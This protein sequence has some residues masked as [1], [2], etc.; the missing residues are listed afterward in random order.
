MQ[1]MLLYEFDNFFLSSLNYQ[2]YAFLIEMIKLVLELNGFHSTLID[3]NY[4]NFF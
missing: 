1:G 2:M 3:K 4:H